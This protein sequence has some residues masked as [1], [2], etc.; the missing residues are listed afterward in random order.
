MSADGSD[1]IVVSPDDTPPAPVVLRFEVAPDVPKR[2][3][4]ELTER[5]YQALAGEVSRMLRAGLL[6]GPLCE[7]RVI[8]VDGAGKTIDTRRR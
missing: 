5:F 3:T 8:P 6:P 1:W 7:V 2:R 4:R